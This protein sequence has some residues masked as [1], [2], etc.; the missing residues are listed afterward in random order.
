MPIYEYECPEHGIFELR[1]GM[2][3]DTKTACPV[4]GVEC[5]RVMSAIGHICFEGR[6][7]PWNAPERVED[8]RRLMKD[9]MVQ[10]ELRKFKE[11]QLDT[12][13]GVF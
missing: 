3:A 5:K 2:F 6:I 13:K 4:C 9:T 11:K 7:L 12:I 8:R 10:K 1:Q